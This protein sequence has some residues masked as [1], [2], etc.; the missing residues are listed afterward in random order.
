MPELA[1]TTDGLHPPKDLFH[2]FSFPLTHE[3]RQRLVIL[4]VGCLPFVLE[5]LEQIHDRR[6]AFHAV[7][8]ALQTAA[9]CP[10]A[11]CF[12]ARTAR[13]KT[14]PRLND[15]GSSEMRRGG[16][17]GSGTGIADSSARV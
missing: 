14:A 11:I 15:A 12:S 9:Q 16:A 13:S 1:Q 3:R 6:F 17:S 8:H 5:P 4:P 2:E 10:S 7:S